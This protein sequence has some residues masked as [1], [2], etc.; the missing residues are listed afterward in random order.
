[1]SIEALLSRQRGKF[2]PVDRSV[3]Q[4]IVVRR[5]HLWQDSLHR[6]QCGLDF[7]KHIRVLFVGEPAVDDGGP[8]RE[9]L[10]LLMGEIS[11]N[12]S[13]FCGQEN[14]RIPAANMAA[15]EK[16]T[17]KHVGQM[18]AVSLLHGGPAPTFFAPSIVDYIIHGIT[19]VKLSIDE[20]PNPIIKSK[21]FKVSY[22]GSLQNIVVIVVSV[23]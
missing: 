10:Y 4:R 5:K 12:N 22:D 19:R 16:H 15:F 6:F 17:Y 9:F 11:A 8:L 2:L 18:I 21:L 3:Y 7:C 13:L 1:M 20:V 23:V 14:I